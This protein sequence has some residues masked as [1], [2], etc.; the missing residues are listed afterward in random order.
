MATV[1]FFGPTETCFSPKRPPDL[2]TIGL[3]ASCFGSCSWTVRQSGGWQ[4]WSSRVSAS[5]PCGTPLQSFRTSVPGARRT[6]RPAPPTSAPG[7][8]SKRRLSA[9]P[10]L[11][12]CSGA[13]RRS[14][15]PRVP[16]SRYRPQRRCQQQAEQAV[17]RGGARKE[18]AEVGH[19]SAR[20]PHLHRRGRIRNRSSRRV[21]QRKPRR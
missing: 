8:E 20:E 6:R 1:A 19:V 11:R 12:G 10:P 16:W 3:L 13:E 14:S 17:C 4:R 15:R 7:P 2:I 9:T 21:F 5:G 18:K